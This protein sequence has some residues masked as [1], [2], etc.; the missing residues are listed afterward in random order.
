VHE[1][2]LETLR[3]AV[4]VSPDGRSLYVL[5]GYDNRTRLSVVARDPR[6]GALS[7]PAGPGKC[8]RVWFVRTKTCRGAPA[9]NNSEAL[10]VPPDSR[11]VVIGAYAASQL[12]LLRRDASGGVRFA[13][14]LG[15]SVGRFRCSGVRGLR[16]IADVAFSSDG[17]NLYVASKQPSAGLLVLG[18]TGAT[19]ALRQL[20]GARGCV[21]E[22]GR[23]Q[24]ERPPCGEVPASAYVPMRVRVSPDDRTVVTVSDSGKE[25]TGIFVFARDSGTGALTPLTCYVAK[26]RPPC[27]ALP[28]ASG[29]DDVVYA[30]DSRALIVSGY[31][32]LDVLTLDPATGTLA[33][34]QCLAAKAAAGCTQASVPGAES[35]ALAPDGRRL[36]AADEHVIRMYTVAS[37]GTLRPVAARTACVAV[38]RVDCTRL[39]I[40]IEGLESPLAVSPDGRWLYSAT[41]GG[42]PIAL[43]VAG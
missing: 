38:V 8:V 11:D 25:G 33:P 21:Q 42:P 43:R 32:T 41:Y 5:G 30:R 37:D 14:C 12:A 16:G 36:Y 4:A 2:V 19:G 26:W 39:P 23:A 15:E 22:Q 24:P 31:E 27:E 17:R 3:G 1:P 20:A 9:L 29:V 35:L 28:T 40:R 13:S 34:R 6:S 10:A 18:R 7:R